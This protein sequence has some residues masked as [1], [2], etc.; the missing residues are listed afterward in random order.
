[1][2][3]GKSRVRGELR[4]RH[5]ATVT[6]RAGMQ[7]LISRLDQVGEGA[8]LSSKANAWTLREDERIRDERD[9]QWV[10]SVRKEGSHLP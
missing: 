8:G 7:L 6:L 4:G 10:S 2:Q 5:L 9:G 1:M 3:F